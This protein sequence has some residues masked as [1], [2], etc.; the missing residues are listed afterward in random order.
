M[1]WLA[2]GRPVLEGSVVAVTDDLLLVSESGVRTS[3]KFK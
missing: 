1:R 3:Y 2:V